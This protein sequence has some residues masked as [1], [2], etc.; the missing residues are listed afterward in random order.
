MI[1]RRTVKENDPNL[2]PSENDELTGR[3]LGSSNAFENTER[4]NKEREKEWSD[5]EIDEMIEDREEDEK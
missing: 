2:T 4:P 5:K 1:K 3:S